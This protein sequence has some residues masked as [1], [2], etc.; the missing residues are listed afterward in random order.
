MIYRTKS[1]FA[2]VATHAAT[3]LALGIYV[4]MAHAW[5]YW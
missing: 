3:N 1:L 2:C 5:Q 4:I